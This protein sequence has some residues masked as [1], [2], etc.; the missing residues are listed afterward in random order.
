MKD[1]DGLYQECMSCRK[2]CPLCRDADPCG[3]RR[4]GARDAEVMFIGE[5]PGENRRT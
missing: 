2:K 3:L 1:W 4:E 5:G